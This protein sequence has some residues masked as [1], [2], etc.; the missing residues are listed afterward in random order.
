VKPTGILET[1]LYAEDLA[2]A[3]HFYEEVLGLHCFAYEE[4]RG[5]FYRCG[6]QMLLVFNPQRTSIA[7]AQGPGVAPP[8][9][10]HGQGHVCF[11]ASAQ[12][13]DQWRERFA[14]HGIA[15]E[16]D[17]EWKW[18][19][20]SLYV[21][22]PAMNCVEFAEPRIWGLDKPPRSLKG[23]SMVI[24]TH[25][26]GKLQEFRSLL[27]PYGIDVKSAGELGLPEPEETEDSF[28]GNARLK[29]KHALQGSG[30]IAISD[31]SGLCVEALQGQPGVHTADWAGPNR[32]WMMAM[33]LVEEKLQAAGARSPQ[34]RKA[35]F[36]CT[37]CVIWPDGE[38]RFYR[39]EAPGHLVWP[40]RGAQGHGY[41][42]VFVPEGHD[43]TFGEMDPARKNMISHR[44]RA[45][46]K[47]AD[48]LL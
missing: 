5:A 26:Q 46:A 35:S 39:G 12:E 44:A 43:I 34:S 48:D 41:D 40:P 36:V 47:L 14:A 24:A 13:L 3:R 15:I 20:R 4:G 10:A 31:D 9:G 30:K 2:A 1:V 33:R 11:K 7:R 27:Q 8:H 17:F 45:L 38:E 37:L 32:D 25:N 6:D 23:S 28:E 22:D 29:A 19:G 16:A 18:G 42:P 21:R